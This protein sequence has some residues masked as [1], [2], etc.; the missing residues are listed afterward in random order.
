MES[1]NSQLGQQ[2]NVNI[3]AGQDVNIGRDLVGGDK[4]EFTFNLTVPKDKSPELVGQFRKLVEEAQKQRQ[5]VKTSS[6]KTKTEYKRKLLYH[7]DLGGTH[8]QITATLSRWRF[9]EAFPSPPSSVQPITAVANEIMGIGGTNSTTFHSP[10]VPELVNCSVECELRIISDNGDVSRWAGF[11]VRGFRDD[12]QFGY[13]V[14]LSLF[15]T[16]RL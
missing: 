14:Y 4:Y 7:L 13:L 12:I 2:G 11:R 1:T 8:Q 16:V 6:R 15:S 10:P 5:E 9:V 3:S